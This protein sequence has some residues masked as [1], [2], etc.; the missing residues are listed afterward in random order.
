VSKPLS[1][2]PTFLNLEEELFVAAP[3]PLE[4]DFAA[5]DVYGCPESA[6]LL[7]PG[8]ALCHACAATFGVG[9]ADVYDVPLNDLTGDERWREA[10]RAEYVERIRALP[11][12]RRDAD[13]EKAITG[14]AERSLRRLDS[15]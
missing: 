11:P 7:I 6:S 3:L 1:A 10:R 13:V 8:A 14:L 12:R 5:C 15:S 9:S 2:A 4:P